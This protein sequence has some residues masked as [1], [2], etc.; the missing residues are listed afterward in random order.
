[1]VGSQ[2]YTVVLHPITPAALPHTDGGG[3]K[4]TVALPDRIV[5]VLEHI[6]APEF[7]AGD[8]VIYTPD[9]G[10][11]LTASVLHTDASH[12]CARAHLMHLI[13]SSTEMCASMIVRSVPVRKSGGSPGVVCRTYPCRCHRPIQGLILRLADPR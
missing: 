8:S 7:E 3:W 2:P 5:S 13:C 4:Y 6:L 1:M 9:G 11:S 10:A 12:W